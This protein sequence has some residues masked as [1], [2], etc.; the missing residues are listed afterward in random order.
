MDAARPIA[1]ALAEDA[2]TPER[3]P[4]ERPASAEPVTI[5][6]ELAEPAPVRTGVEP[7]AEARG[8]VRHVAPAAAAAPDVERLVALHEARPQRVRDDGVM[9][10][11]VEHE[12]LGP[13]ELRIAVRDHGVR[14]ELTAS[15]EHARDTLVAGRGSL[16]AALDRAQLRL[17]TFDV[18]TGGQQ[19]QQRP[20]GERDVRVPLPPAPPPTTFDRA[21]TAP[22][23]VP[24]PRPGHVSLRA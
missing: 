15:H 4:G 18:Q 21:A 2:H 20:S 11:E 23:P 3:E 10:L 14:A 7:A 16:E 8:T 9:R 6:R 24:A 12:D 19:H 22:E 1:A 17:D 5:V 13:I